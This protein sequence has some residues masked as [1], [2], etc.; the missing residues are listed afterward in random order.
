MPTRIV[1]TNAA[2][3]ATLTAST[4]AGSLAASNLLTLRKAQVWRATGTSANLTL[5]WAAAQTIGM[6]A[7]P[8]CNLTA[9]ATLR[10]RGYTLAA[11]ASPAFDTT[12]LACCAPD[13][14][15]PQYAV[16]WFTPA[17]VE[18]LVIDIADASN[19]AGYVQAGC[20]VAGNYWQPEIGPSHGGVTLGL[21][22][23]TVKAR[24]DGGDPIA[25]SGHRH[26]TLSL[27]FN[28]MSETDRATAFALQATN[29]TAL[30]V[31]ASVFAGE[32][33]ALEHAHQIWGLLDEPFPI[34]LPH[35]RK[36]A[37]DLTVE[38]I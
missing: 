25:Q 4:T 16:R 18:K 37:A 14:G 28:A 10:V 27:S 19:P 32:G 35:Y 8:F 33:T 15:W 26:R 12:A 17:A 13:T 22:D 21:G 3:T 2:Q 24:T 31:F 20:L 5:V 30:P 29:G 9:G 7:L 1:S 38:E 6:V 36:Y 11:D 23:A 34:T